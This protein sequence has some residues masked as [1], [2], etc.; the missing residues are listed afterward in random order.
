MATHDTSCI[1]VLIAGNRSV[2]PLIILP[3]MIEEIFDSRSFDRQCAEDGDMKFI[4]TSGA[5]AAPCLWA[6]IVLACVGLCPR[7]RG[8]SDQRCDDMTSRNLQIVYSRYF[9]GR[10]N[11]QLNKRF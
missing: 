6:F 8:V 2:Q 3:A 9:G 11:G 1:M 4:T 5:L 10:Q 7:V